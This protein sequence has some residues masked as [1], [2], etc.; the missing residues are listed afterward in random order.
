MSATGLQRG[1]S[2]GALLGW[3][4]RRAPSVQRLP[5]ALMSADEVTAEL[6]R[7][8]ARKA[9]DAAYEAELVLAL[10]AA[11]R[12]PCSLPIV[13]SGASCREISVR[14]PVGTRPHCRWN[15]RHG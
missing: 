10:A 7:V 6:E 3:M 11:P 13:V 9:M 4:L 14:G 15:G 2:E 1:L 5:V 8:Q 12:V